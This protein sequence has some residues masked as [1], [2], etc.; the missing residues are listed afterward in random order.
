MSQHQQQQ[1]TIAAILCRSPNNRRKT[2]RHSQWESKAAGQSTTIFAK[3]WMIVLALLFLGLPVFLFAEIEVEQKVVHHNK[4]DHHHQLQH[5][6]R[7]N[8][9]PSQ[10][11]KVDAIVVGSGLAGMTATLRILDRGGSVIMIEKESILGGNSNK[12]SSGINACCLERDEKFND[13]IAEFLQDTLQSAGPHANIALIETL[14]DHSAAAVNWL[15]N[16]VGV[17]LSQLVLLGGHS[18]PRTHRPQFGFVGAEIMSAIEAAI[19]NYR[20]TGRINVMLNTQ[21]LKL[22]HDEYDH[23]Q[24]RGVQIRKLHDKHHLKPLNLYANDVIL[25]TGGF[26]SDRSRGSLLEKYRPDLISLGATAGNFSTGDGIVMAEALGAMTLDMEKVQ[27]HPTGFV[28]PQQPDNPNKVLAAELLRGV[29]GI[30]LNR[31][32]QRFCNELGRRNYVVDKMM[33]QKERSGEPQRRLGQRQS[34]HTFFLVL[35]SDSANEAKSHISHY[36][37]QHL[38]TEVSGVQG[39]S[40]RIGVSRD[41]IEKTLRQ[42]QTHAVTGKADE[43]GKT[44]FSGFPLVNFDTETFLVGE[45]TPVLHY[46][47]GGIGI[48]AA[49]HVLNENGERIWGLHAAG[50]VTGGVHGNNRL[51]GNSLLECAVFGSIV[52]ESIPIV[53]RHY[54]SHNGENQEVA[55]PLDSAIFQN[56]LLPVITE[57][58]LSRHNTANDSW[59]AIHGHVYDLTS[60]L[61]EHP[62]GIDSVASL[63]GMDGTDVFAALHS[64]RILDRLESQIVGRL[65]ASAEFDL[66]K[67][68]NNANVNTKH[69][70]EN[71]SL[72][73]VWLHNSE[74]DCW[75]CIHGNVFDVT[76]FAKTH[77]GGSH[78]I[79]KHCGKD[80]TLE[81][82]VFHK[83]GIQLL[84]GIEHLRLGELSMW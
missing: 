42:Y 61:P 4:G 15:Y 22:L 75:I 30:L 51:G 54:D 27:I 45:V 19:Y 49:G 52:G 26:A 77:P 37:Y 44:V 13:T 63:S 1:Q 48:D 64:R 38:M 11:P 6:L 31:D 24:V 60:F 62:G 41:V 25:A 29:G 68:T 53:E 10:I 23:N 70:E 21:V 17:D 3:S 35:P 12:A 40:E 82:E 18:K 33:N 9:H 65:D 69:P 20:A 32:G 78:M 67:N 2:I 16:R 56:P 71:L 50:E 46:C 28:D 14:V 7:E 80:A 66:N 55:H 47:M 5:H 8:V 74:T 73:T 83:K 39:L 76:I 36:L 43:H 57:A 84:N 72:D 81:F 59:V 58:E 34:G 79:H